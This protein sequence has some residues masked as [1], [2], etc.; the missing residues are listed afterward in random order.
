[1]RRARDC[2]FIVDDS[3]RTIGICLGADY[4][5]EHEFGI[6]DLRKA[7]GIPGHPGVLS[8]FK[9]G[10]TVR[11]PVEMKVGLE[12]RKI[13]VV[14]A[15][16]TFA[17]GLVKKKKTAFLI[18]ESGLS[19]ETE[20]GK[21]VFKR[22][23]E[24]LDIYAEDRLA[25]AWDSESFGIATDSEQGRESL[26]QI[27]AAFKQKDIAIF[28]GGRTTPFQNPGLNFVIASRVPANHADNMMRSDLDRV[29]LE[30]IALA[31]GIKQKLKEAG[32]QYFALSP[33]WINEQRTGVRFWLNPM[34][35][36]ANK[37]G[38]YTTEEL[39]QWTR[40][41]GPVLKN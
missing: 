25:T 24:C 22:I 18:H 30:K 35:Q 39:E 34:E 15:G 41:Q 13:T 14:P 10:N 28:I 27:S 5:A 3:G 8:E 7:F 23:T 19:M 33:A 12:A 1:M 4:C 36:K 20:W 11:E 38:W 2:G 16:L 29:A 6:E 26:L 32:K 37:A 17:E 31:T 40:N 9:F 21:K